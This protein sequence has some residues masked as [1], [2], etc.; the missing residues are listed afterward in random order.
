MSDLLNKL[1]AKPDNSNKSSVKGTGNS[2]PHQ[3]L[4]KSVKS[5]SETDLGSDLISKAGNSK[6]S[7][8]ATGKAEGTEG[9]NEKSAS[10]DG[11]SAGGDFVKDPDSWT[12]ESALKEIKRL[13]E[14]NKTYRSTLSTKYE[15]KLDRLK[16]EMDARI[17]AKEATL[18]ELQTAK[19]E[20]ED[21]KAKEADKKRDLSEKLAHREAL[22]ADIK[23]KHEAEVKVLSEKLTDLNQ[24]VSKFEADNEAQ[25]EV[26]KQRLDKELETVPEKYKSV[27]TL[28]I[29]GA[30][31]PREALVA[32]NEA[33]IQGVF[34]DK[35]VVVNHGVPGAKDGARST[36]EKL[37]E[38][39][40]ASREKMTSQQKIAEGLRSIREGK[41]NNMV[42]G[43]RN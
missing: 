2:E 26:Y 7:T 38:A 10:S 13:R 11:E 21:I 8:A 28:I 19:E 18:T 35:T 31:D 4:D 33:K 39:A 29:K 42:K 23:A 40:K 5:S 15:E 12:K 32:L 27:A 25:L 20:L 41:P 22:L 1:G 6:P 36:K 43:L 3:A 34:E 37:D 17:S 9:E 24:K 16:A 30:G 14:E